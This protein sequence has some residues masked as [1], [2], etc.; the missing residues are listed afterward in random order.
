MAE[1]S[2][3]ITIASESLQAAIHPLGAQLFSLRDNSGRDLQWDGD[4]AIWKGR[5]PI[6]FPIIGELADG[7]YSLDGKAYRLSRHGFARDRLFDLIKSDPT[8]ALFRLDWDAETFEIYPFHFELDVSFAI[9]GPA[10]TVTASIR[11]TGSFEMPAGFGFHP[12]LRW[13][14]PYGEAR[15]DHRIVFERDE[16]SSIRRL[17]QKGLLEPDPI[18]SPVEGR[19][20]RLRDDLFDH[21]AL[22]FDR[23][24]SSRLWYGALPGPQIRFDFPDTPYLA[25]WTKPGAD[26]IC[27]EPWHGQADPVGFSGDFRTKPGIFNVS[28]GQ[29]KV[30]AMTLTLCDRAP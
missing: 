29:E 18:A 20:L 25:I 8:T 21:D 24:Q 28:P 5:A 30:C 22:I 9:V 4:P 12:A 15:A 3:L 11:N 13:P 2:Q 6:L 17:D 19:V 26:F 23:L 14:L 10:L 16:P 1:A 7:Q 27:I